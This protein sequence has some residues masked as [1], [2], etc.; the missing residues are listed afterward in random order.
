MT[1]RALDEPLVTWGECFVGQDNPEGVIVALPHDA[2]RLDVGLAIA[3]TEWGRESY[4][5]QPGGVT[6][7]QAWARLLTLREQWVWEWDK[8]LPEEPWDDPPA[9]YWPQESTP[10]WIEDAHGSEVWIAEW[11]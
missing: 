1:R 11:T 4:L 8:A 7:R 10:S 2:D 9:D 5:P 3:N 6:V